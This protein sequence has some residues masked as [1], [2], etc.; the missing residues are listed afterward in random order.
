MKLLTL[1]LSLILVDS[2]KVSFSQ[3]PNNIVRLCVRSSEK[4]KC[5]NNYKASTNDYVNNNANTKSI[6]IEIPVI[7]YKNK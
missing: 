1:L 6:T 4:E 3:I 5:L 2:R 7:P